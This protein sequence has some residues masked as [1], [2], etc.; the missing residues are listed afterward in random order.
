MI[1]H[2][3]L[4]LFF[5]LIIYFI[6]GNAVVEEMGDSFRDT[7]A[8]TL[9]ADGSFIPPF[10]IK[11]QV[12]N[13]SKASGRRPTRGEKAQKG[14]TVPKMI[15]YLD[16]VAKYVDRH[17]VLVLDRLSSHISKKV[18]KYAHSLRCSDGVTQKFEILL[19]PAKA[20]FLISPLDMGFFSTWKRSYYKYDRSTYALKVQ[21]AN[22]VWK[23]VQPETIISLFDNCGITSKETGAKLR[24]RIAA[25]VRSGMP[26]ELEEVWEFYQGW[27]GGA[28]DIEG[29]TRPR[30]PPTEHLHIPLNSELDGVYW[31][32]RG[33]QMHH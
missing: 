12:G 7:M 24:K 5:I 9:V 22:L 16:H 15:E 11:G 31:I 18:I 14:M 30:A 4:I 32:K 25:Q 19:L 20:S 26:E 27:L 23:S 6:S 17:C 28:F 10:Y 2:S 8:A 3:N 1:K 13:A 21:A 33:P 29:A